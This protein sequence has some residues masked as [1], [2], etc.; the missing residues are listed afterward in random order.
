MPLAGDYSLVAPLATGHQPFHQNAYPTNM[1]E[2]SAW[3]KQM[4]Q[5][6]M[7]F[8]NSNSNSNN[9]SSIADYD[10]VGLGHGLHGGDY[11][12]GGM[13]H[14]GI[15][16]ISLQRWEDHFSPRGFA[17][18]GGAPQVCRTRVLEIRDRELEWYNSRLASSISVHLALGYHALQTA[19]GTTSPASLSV[20]LLMTC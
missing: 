5:V 3:L 6:Q 20:S 4:P 8:N 15:P 16:N 11:D 12:M 17:R 14:G 7:Q 9:N 2:H 19:K 13:P 10:H 1:A 18:Y